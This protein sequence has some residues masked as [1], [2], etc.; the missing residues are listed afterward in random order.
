MESGLRLPTPDDALCLVHKD[1]N[2]LH[3]LDLQCPT[4]YREQLAAAVGARASDLRLF[5]ASPRVPDACLAGVIC[6]TV[7]AVVELRRG[8]P[9]SPSGCLLDLRA[10]LA[11]WHVI[12]VL[13]D[14]I[15][16][17]AVLASIAELVPAG[18]RAKL[19]GMPPD[20]P[21]VAVVPG[22]VLVV[23]LV[24]AVSPPMLAPVD[25][26]EDVG[27]DATPDATHGSSSGAGAEGGLAPGPSEPSGAA[28]FQGT[29]VEVLPP[30]L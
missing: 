21:E 23:D 4:R 12:E 25:G 11:G 8:L 17:P 2:F 6:R 9:E 16:C 27:H 18:W 7:L 15:S 5:P 22:Q 20:Q 29:G 3:A 13:A 24:P 30:P 19:R 1:G 14:R 10:L 28:S 26:P